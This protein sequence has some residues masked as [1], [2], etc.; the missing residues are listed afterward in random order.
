MARRQGT[1]A[2]GVSFGDA[3]AIAKTAQAAPL[4]IESPA[5]ES[6][7]AELIAELEGSRAL[8]LEAERRAFCVARRARK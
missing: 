5:E 6:E 4:L 8:A 3:K 2:F 1:N 7:F